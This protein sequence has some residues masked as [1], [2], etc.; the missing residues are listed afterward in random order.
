MFILGVLKTLP[1]E[2]RNKSRNRSLILMQDVNRFQVSCY[3]SEDHI[4]RSFL[5]TLEEGVFGLEDEITQ[6]PRP[7][8]NVMSLIESS[9]LIQQFSGEDRRPPFK[10][11]RRLL[12]DAAFRA[13]C[14]AREFY[15]S[16]RT[17]AFGQP[18]VEVG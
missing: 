11:R 2:K 7:L 4:Q 16:V 18:N 8:S 10:N 6:M 9:S 13:M 14:A 12:G 3:K 1:L 5:Y 15:R 17:S